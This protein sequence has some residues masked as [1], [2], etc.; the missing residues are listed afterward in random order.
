MQALCNDPSKYLEVNT[1][2][3][4]SCQFLCDK[5]SPNGMA[6]KADPSH[7]CYKALKKHCAKFPESHACIVQN[8]AY[9]CE[10]GKCVQRDGGFFNSIGSC[11]SSCNAN[12]PNTS[13]PKPSPSSPSSSSSFFPSLMKNKAVKIGGGIVLLILLIL[14]VVFF[15]KRKRQQNFHCYFD[16]DE[17]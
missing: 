2:Y 10:S 4:A 1:K 9:A 12:T 16:F 11:R 15:L 14:L 3:N 7:W 6:R 5:R 8:D 17:L 13:P